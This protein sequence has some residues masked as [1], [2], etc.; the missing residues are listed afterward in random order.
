VKKYK[1][2]EGVTMPKRMKKNYLISFTAVVVGFL[3]LCLVFD[4][5]LLGKKSAYF[6]GLL[7]VGMFY[8]I[9]VCSLNLLTGYMGEFSLG[10]AGFMS[11]G[12]YVSAI[13][14]T[15]IQYKVELPSLAIYII[16]VL[17]GGI[18]AA[19]I[20]VLVGIPALRLSGDYLCIV[21]VAVAEI[22]RVVLS[23]F[24]IPIITGNATFGKSFSGIAKVSDYHYV[25]ITMVISIVIMYCYIRSRYGRALIAI[26]EDRIA[27]AASGINVTRTKV[28]TFTISAFFAGVAGAIY[29]H[30]ITILVP[31]YFNFS[32]SS[33]FLAIVILGGSG[34]LTGS[35]VAAPILSALPQLISYVLPAFASYRML[36]YAIILVVVMIF[37]PTGLFGGREFSL[38]RLIDKIARKDKKE[39]G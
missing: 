32:K 33:E 28:L 15:L 16:A 12:A 38:P 23:N 37:K 24:G 3:L 10:H 21:T 29:A 22:V 39:K 35:I 7:V 25:Y 9:I 36:I 14:T 18:S 30:Y 11:I 19:L 1:E 5:G 26:R 2:K 6:N 8:T 20:G 34:S 13:V 17:V 4:T 27:A 31:T